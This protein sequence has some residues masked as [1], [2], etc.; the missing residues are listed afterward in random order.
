M[1][2]RGPSK[3]PTKIL[4][5]RGSWLAKLPERRDEIQPPVGA[6]EM[7]DWL[8]GLAREVWKE[9]IG[10]LVELGVVTRLDGDLFAAYCA[11]YS[12]MV[13]FSKAVDEEGDVVETTN[14]GIKANP[15]VAMLSTAT[16]QV[17]RLAGQFGMSPAKRSDV[18]AVKPTGEESKFW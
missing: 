3:T 15:K 4:E 5:R 6:P 7:P 1:G 9:K 18:K 13:R 17:N 10:P 8:D 16:E 2:K 11:A 14:G 12:R